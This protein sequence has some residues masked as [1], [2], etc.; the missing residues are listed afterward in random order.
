M[1]DLVIHGG[2][3]PPTPCRSCRTPIVFAKSYTTGKTAPFEKDDA[4]EWVLENGVAKHV[5]PVPAQLELGG[6]Q[7]PQRWTSHFARC[8]QAERWR[9]PR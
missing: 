5:G 8:P 1:G 3:A 4:G 7:P 6:E 2:T 9:N